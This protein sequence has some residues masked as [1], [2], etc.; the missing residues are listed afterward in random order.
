MKQLKRHNKFKTLIKSVLHYFT[1]FRY[2]KNFLL[3]LKYPFIKYYDWTGC[4]IGYSFT[5]YDEIPEGWRIAFGKQFL[6]DL[7]KALKEDNIPKYKWRDN[8]SFG[9]IKEK[10]G[11][12]SISACTT[13]RVYDAI[14]KYEDLSYD[15]CIHCGKPTKY[16]TQG[17]ITF[18]CEDC[19][20]SKYKNK[21]ILKIMDEKEKENNANNNKDE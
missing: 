19:A 10:W 7:A 12:L 3:C 1:L 5:W 13:D 4:F 18:I 8:L 14:S 15:Y 16:M 20:K 11:F 2:P 6:E 9:E 21:D 17:Y